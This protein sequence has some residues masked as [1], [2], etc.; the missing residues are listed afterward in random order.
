MRKD[1]LD[2]GE[3][4]AHIGEG[5]EHMKLGGRLEQKL[6]IVLAMDIGQMRRQV[7]QQSR[8]GGAVI[9]PGAAFTAEKH[10]AFQQQVAVLGFEPCLFE[11]FATPSV[12]SNTPEMRA[13]SLPERMVSAEARPPKQQAQ[14][15]HNDRFAATGFARE[16]IEARMETDA[17]PVD[18]SVVLKH[19]LMQHSSRL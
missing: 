7:L 6:L 5:I 2:S 1:L 13:R 15:V 10:F 14:G 19:Q 17:Q 12:V 11:H 18:H 8:G 3:T 16:E 4:L 9:H